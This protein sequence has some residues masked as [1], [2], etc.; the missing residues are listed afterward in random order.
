V[1]NDN[2]GSVAR[3]GLFIVGSEVVPEAEW[4][5]MAPPGVSVH[6]ARVT[7]AAPWAQWRE[8]RASVELAPDLER[9][10]AQFASMALSAV[11]LAH[12]S[13]SIVGGSGW[14]NAVAESLRARLRPSTAVAT[15]G[16][17]CAM[18][19]RRCGVR[20]PLIVYPPWF[21]EKAMTA[22]AAYFADL[23][24][25]D[26]RTFRH[27]PEPRWAKVPPEDLYKNLM[28]ME[29]KAD[30]L[31]D[32]IVATCPAT[33]DGVLIAGTGLRCV[34]IIDALEAALGRPVVTANQASLWR[35]LSL[36]GVETRITG[37]GQL[38][39]GPRES[40]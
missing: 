34:G 9:G 17:D 23:G 4:W 11:V 1:S 39:A 27:A 3:F 28:H 19:L 8:D 13:S 25:G 33:A 15:N 36:A 14:D 37:Y 2:W 5:A 38:L 16:V 10:A 26:I 29:Q 31:C 12:T 6:A 22:G 30:L 40:R 20:R 7:A 24:F 32:Q 18:A 35:C 21:G